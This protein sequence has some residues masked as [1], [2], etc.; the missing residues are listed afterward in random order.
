MRSAAL[1]LISG[2]AA[3]AAEVAP[4]GGAKAVINSACTVAAGE[5]LPE[6]KPI[7]RATRRVIGGLT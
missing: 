5:P 7:K 6:T 2:E 4:P 1:M 3:A